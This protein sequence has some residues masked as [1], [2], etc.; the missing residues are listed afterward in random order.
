MRKAARVLEVTGQ[1]ALVLAVAHVYNVEQTYGFTLLLPWIL[2]GFLVHMWLPFRWRLPFF[3]LLT[4]SALVWLLGFPHGPAVI[5]LGVGLIGLCHLP[6]A[7]RWRV[8]MVV[9]AGAGLA[10]LRSGRI[11]LP[12]WQALPDVV[13]PMLAGLFMFR[14]IVYL[15]ALRHERTPATWWERL[16]YFFLLPNLCMPLFPVVDFATFRRSRQAGRDP[17]A[18]ARKGIVWMF[19]GITH[20]I[21]YRAVYLYLVPDPATVEGPGV[22]VQYMVATF[23][24]YLRVSGLFHLAVGV[25]VLFGWDLPPVFRRYGLA[26]SFRDFWRRAN[27][28][29]RDFMHRLIFLPVVMRLRRY[30][31]GMAVVGAVLLVFGVSWLLHAYQWFWLRGTLAGAETGWVFWGGFGG[32]VAVQAWMDLRRRGREK[33]GSTIGR[34][35]RPMA[36]MLV[37]VFLWMFWTH[38]ASGATGVVRGLVAAKTMLWVV[39]IGMIGG[40]VVV[41]LSGGITRRRPGEGGSDAS[42]G[43]AWWSMAGAA[44]LLLLTTGPVGHLAPPDVRQGLAELQRDRFNQRDDVLGNAGYYEGLLAPGSYTA[45]LWQVLGRARRPGAWNRTLVEAGAARLTG[46]LLGYALV[47]GRATPFR[48]TLLRVNGHG[49]RDREYTF[50]KPPGTYRIALLGASF[51]MGWGVANEETFEA[52]LEQLLNRHPVS[53]RYTRYEVLNFAVTGYSLLQQV[54]LAEERVGAF[55]P[56]ALFLKVGAGSRKRLVETLARRIREGVPL[57]Y[58]FL[59]AVR[60]HAGAGAGDPQEELERRLIPY[61]DTLVAWA[62][63]RIAEACRRQG[64]LPVFYVTPVLGRHGEAQPDW[65]AMREQLLAAGFVVLR[66]DDAYE[67]HDEQALW[68]AP[69][70]SHPNAAAH[71][72]VALRLYEVIREHRTELGL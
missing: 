38:S 2:G 21:A 70:D 10:A 41:G 17:A 22:A 34:I 65:E 18:T 15:H 7:F 66:A 60:Q 5:A 14:L 32:L 30:G 33:A 56:D 12:A 47:P 59:E 49:L 27:S 13:I 16:G 6:L 42:H 25:L 8:M 45:A 51:A 61:A 36:V 55:A 69:W 23:L 68:L 54:V 28:Y 53:P 46:D 58:A 9:L 40:A 50:E 52:R 48:G 26:S 44:G 31:I 62:Y 64:I 24:L 1:L 67:G 35:V 71:R 39:L 11:V 19:R 20:L 72:L 37:V 29:W 43:V 57:R 4:G 63:R 3:V